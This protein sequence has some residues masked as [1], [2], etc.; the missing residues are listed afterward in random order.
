VRLFPVL[1]ALITTVQADFRVIFEKDPAAR[2]W[3]EVLTCYPG[4]HAL[5]FHRIAHQLYALRLYWLARLIAH[6]GRGLTGVEIH[7]GATIGKG[8]FIDHGMGVVVGETAIIGDGVLIY[9]G[10]TLG[11]T[12]KQ[13]GK[14]HPTLGNNVVVGAGAKVLGNIE[15]GHDTRIGAGSV[16]L[17][18][19]PS[20][21][22]VVGVPGR[23]VYQAGERI[24]ALAHGQ[25][26][27]PVTDVIRNLIQRVEDLEAELQ[28]RRVES[29]QLVP[30]HPVEVRACEDFLHGSGI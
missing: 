30:T 25:V 9:Q 8:V 20:D 4:F 14:R 28:Q 15:V 22:T 6:I 27:D 7:P 13:K 2:S 11:G 5:V 1:K 12:G 10:V 29:G 19:V 18:T 17:R 24:D 26:P 23:V 21:C 16:L 3:L